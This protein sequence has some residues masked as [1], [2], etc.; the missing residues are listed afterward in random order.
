[1]PKYLIERL[2]PEADKLSAGDLQ[3]I[4]QKS[5]SV[6]NEMGPRIQWIQSFVTADGIYCTYIAPN[7]DMIREHAS[8]GGFS[9]NRI[10]EVKS[11]ID[12]TTAEASAR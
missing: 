12:P 2:I 11:I 9:A 1:M 8:Q 7:E 10:T 3:G 5:C 6:L 4:A